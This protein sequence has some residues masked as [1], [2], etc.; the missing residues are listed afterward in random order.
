MADLPGTEVVDRLAPVDPAERDRW[1]R[2]LDED[3]AH[4]LAMRSAPALRQVEVGG[5]PTGG[6]GDTLDVVAWNLERGTHVDAAGDVLQSHQPD[7][8]LLSEV[9]VGMARSGNRHTVAE[10]A[11][12]LGHRYAYAVEFVELGLGDAGE[13]ERLDPDA[14]NESGFHGNGITSR[15][16]LAEVL[17]IRIEAGGSWFHAETD[18]PRVGGRMALA[19]R[20]ELEGRPV[21][22]CSLHLESGSDPSMRADQLAIVLEA[23]DRRYG[24]LSCVVGGDLNTFSTSLEEGRTRFRELR[25]EDPTRFCWPVPYEPLFEVAARHG[26][27]VDAANDAEQTMRLRAEQRPG[28]LLRLD[29]LLVRDLQ[30]T[31]H[32]TVPAVDP[33]G[34]VISDHDAVSATLHHLA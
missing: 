6:S 14:T 5:D 12:R 7:V 18:Q 33:Q 29:W 4:A 21:V 19:A 13:A 10:L 17:L 34:L 30:V 22:V 23:I 8:V 9:D 31:A 3:G 16:P 27:D 20:I 24:A 28:S 26:F 15:L 2:S 32:A 25:D 1:L 11:A